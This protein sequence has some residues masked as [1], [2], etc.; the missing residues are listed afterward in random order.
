MLKQSMILY[1]FSITGSVASLFLIDIVTNNYIL[2]CISWHL[3]QSYSSRGYLILFLCFLYYFLKDGF[4]FSYSYLLYI[5]V[6]ILIFYYKRTC[7]FNQNTTIKV[8]RVFLTFRMLNS[9]YYYYP[10]TSVT[11]SNPTFFILDV[12]IRNPSGYVIYISH[13]VSSFKKLKYIVWISKYVINILR[14]S[15]RYCKLHIFYGLFP[16]ILTY[17]PIRK[18]RQHF[19][20]VEYT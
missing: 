3:I 1:T 7:F 19:F 4:T 12:F 16:V 6:Y 10:S 13:K 20:S 14:F 5:Q 8:Y 15:Q 18:Y 2:Y 9:I 17:T 11:N